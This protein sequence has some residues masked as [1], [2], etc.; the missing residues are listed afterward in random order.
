MNHAL[1]AAVP[2][3]YNIL[4]TQQLQTNILFRLLSLFYLEKVKV[5]PHLVRA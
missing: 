5:V 2:S 1:S 3:R 4:A